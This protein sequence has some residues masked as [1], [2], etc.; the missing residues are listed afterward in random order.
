MPESLVLVLSD[1]LY[2]PKATLPPALRNALTR[3]AAFQT[4]E[5]YRAQA[6]RLSTHDKPRIIACAEDQRI[7]G[8][9]DRFT[10]LRP[11]CEP[12]LRARRQ[13]ARRAPPVPRLRP[14]GAPCARVDTP[15]RSGFNRC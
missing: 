4:P 9:C 6:M 8:E 10:D 7:L 12:E 13:A 1:Q 3:L 15:R 5:F 14:S 11:A 2:V